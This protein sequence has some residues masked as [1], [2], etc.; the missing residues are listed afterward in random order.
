MTDPIKTDFRN[1]V[2]LAWE[3]LGLPNPAPIQ[4]DVA[5]YIA[6]GPDRRM[7]QAMRGF[8]KSYLTATYAAW[9]L[10]CNPD[11]TM[12]CLSA[13]GNRSREFIRL[14]RQLV[15]ALPVCA[16]MVPREGDRDGADRFDVGNR[17]KVSKDPSCAAYGINSM[18]TG[19]HVDLI[20]LDDIEIPENSSTVEAREKLLVKLA[21]AENIL[22]P[23]GDIVYLGTP[24]TEDSVYNKLG[25]HYLVRRWPARAPDPENDNAML[26]IA[27]YIADAMARGDLE[28]GGPTYPEYYPDDLLVERQGIM[29]P[30]IFALQ[31][32]LDTTLADVERYPLKLRNFIVTDIHG[33]HA[34][35]QIAWGTTKVAKD[36]PSVGLGKDFFH[37]P[38]WTSDDFQ[39]FED[40]ILYVDPSGRGNDQTGYC[41]GRLLKGSIWIPEAGGL[42]GGYD[43]TTLEQLSRLVEK[44]HVG[45]VVVESNYGDGMFA[46][47]LAPV[48]GRIA[49][50]CSIVEERVS[51]QKEPRI[52]DTIEPALANHRIVIDP[53]VARNKELMLQISRITRER[54]SLR[55]DDQ[56]E[57]LAGAIRYFTG[58]L[59]IDAERKVADE[60]K[61]ELQKEHESF[62]K[63]WRTGKS[64]NPRSVVIGL[65]LPGMPMGRPARG[66][67]GGW[68]I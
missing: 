1:F 28:P 11:T 34:P 14:T 62:E 45:T 17:S 30:S 26:N 49:G 48:L 47:L 18:I 25:E 67:K 39:D 7:I 44:Y 42:T 6:E 22:N 66:R 24:Q 54:G 23:G 43:E 64:D 55:H 57:A 16:R 4:Y 19:T 56:V 59:A 15:A 8:G 13:T 5:S 61:A 21:E 3:A 63:A 38:V 51:G 36:L 35:A 37:Y 29:G 10:Y 52:I 2:Y 32:L 46:S 40:S 12:L 53:E 41:V 50:N 27:P 33:D 31:M 58:Q 60:E 65:P 68:G 20:I 9:R